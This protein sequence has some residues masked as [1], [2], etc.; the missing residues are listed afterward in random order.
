ML[1]IAT[2]R[3]TLVAPAESFLV[4]KDSTLRPG[5]EG[6]AQDWGRELAARL[7]PAKA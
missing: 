7:V 1:L 2:A 5:E 4:T 3:R 6:R